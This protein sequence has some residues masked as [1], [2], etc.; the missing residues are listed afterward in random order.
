MEKSI[1]DFRAGLGPHTGGQQVPRGARAG[2]PPPPAPR[3]PPAARLLD[4]FDV[5]ILMSQQCRRL[6]SRTGL[7]PQTG[8]QQVPRGACARQRRASALRPR[9][10]RSPGQSRHHLLMP[11]R[12]LACNQETDINMRQTAHQSR[13]QSLATCNLQFRQTFTIF[14][15]M[16]SARSA[17]NY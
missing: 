10:C 15:K 16:F 8:S 17:T 7:G 3:H 4:I 5:F 12:Q 1:Y 2:T 6:R 13:S 11:G 9:Q 14:L